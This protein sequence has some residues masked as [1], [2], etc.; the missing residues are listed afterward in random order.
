MMAPSAA[1]TL[2][3]L[4]K[5]FPKCSYAGYDISQH[6]LDLAAERCATFASLVSPELTFIR[7]IN[8]G[9]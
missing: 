3:T 5:V 1:E 8:V 2:M 6:S 7:L 9:H 4:A